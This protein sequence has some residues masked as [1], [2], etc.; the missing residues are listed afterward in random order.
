MVFP[1]V[2]VSSKSASDSCWSVIV[3]SSAETAFRQGRAQNPCYGSED[4]VAADQLCRLMRIEMASVI[5]YCD[6]LTRITCMKAG[7]DARDACAGRFRCRR[8][9]CEV[10]RD[11]DDEGW[12]SSATS[13]CAPV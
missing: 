13:Q 10:G 11:R 12:S 1:N 9:D 4:V 3:R 6:V 2:D 8:G 5:R 7:R